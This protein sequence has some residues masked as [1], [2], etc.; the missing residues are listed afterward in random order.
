MSAVA[1]APPGPADTYAPVI[2]C[3]DCP[4]LCHVTGRPGGETWRQC[5]D[6]LYAGRPRR[7]PDTVPLALR[8][9]ER[10]PGCLLVVVRRAGGDQVTHARRGSRWAGPSVETREA[11]EGDVVPLLRVW[12]GEVLLG[13][14]PGRTGQCP[15]GR[16]VSQDRS[17][18][19][20]AAA[21]RER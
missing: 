3:L 18:A 13:R 11:V 15:G 4:H 10:Y 6:V 21:H 7:G 17:G 5:A 8:T 1:A 16:G 2:V 9:L 12:Y 20:R 19:L 14:S